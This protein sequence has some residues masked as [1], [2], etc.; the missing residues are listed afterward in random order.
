MAD[1]QLRGNEQ[2]LDE[3]EQGPP[4]R[5][6]VLLASLVCLIL[7]AAVIVGGKLLLFEDMSTLGFAIRTAIILAVAL[8]LWLAF[9]RRRLARER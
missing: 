1:D 5:W 7:P 6:R 8:V 4:P 9:F 2:Y 3:V